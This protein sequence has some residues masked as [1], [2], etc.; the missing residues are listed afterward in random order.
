MRRVVLFGPPCGT[1]LVATFPFMLFSLRTGGA[2]A[3]AVPITAIDG[4]PLGAGTPG[5][6]FRRI[7]DLYFD[8]VRGKREEYRGW[9]TEA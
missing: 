9:L 1:L 3:V 5:P 2:A 6:L 7:H 8:V 4:H